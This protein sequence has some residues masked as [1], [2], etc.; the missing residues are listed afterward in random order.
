MPNGSFQLI[1]SVACLQVPQA[2]PYK[3][4]KAKEGT[5][6][7]KRQ[8]EMNAAAERAAMGAGVATQEGHE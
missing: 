2:Q 8:A 5:P 7:A 3:L 4:A 1:L 6:A